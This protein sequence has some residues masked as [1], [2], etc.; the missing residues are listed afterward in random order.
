MIEKIGDIWE[1]QGPKDFVVITT[2]TTCRKDGCLVMGAGI[3]KEAAQK[4][5]WLPLALGQ[6]IKRNG[7]QVEVYHPIR[8]IAFPVKYDWRVP[9]DLNLIRQSTKQLL[10]K[11]ER[12]QLLLRP[13]NGDVRILIPRPGC[14]N[15]QREWSEVEPILR[16]YLDDDRYV[17]FHKE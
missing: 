12:L 3:A 7:A 1:A 8:L 15:G 14:G 9:A 5:K 13:E 10:H 4:F 17:I 11:V 16:Q 2:N 6:D